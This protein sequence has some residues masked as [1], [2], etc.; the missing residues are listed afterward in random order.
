MMKRNEKKVPGFDEII[1]ENRNRE[2]GAYQLRKRYNSATSFSILVA[3]AICTAIVIGLQLT[4]K[5]GTATEGKGIIVIVQPESYNP[6]LVKPPEVKPPRDLIKPPQNVA[7]K[8][9]DSTIQTTFI[10]ITDVITA[11]TVNGDV[12]D[13]VVYIETSVD[14]VPAEPPVFI[15]VEEMPEF[16]G[17][18]SALLEFIGKNT[19]YPTEAIENN[20]EGRVILKFVVTPNGSVGKIEILKGVDPLLDKEAIRVVGTLPKFRPGKQSGVPVNVWYSVPVL[21]QIK[22]SNN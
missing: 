10:P 14:V 6:D 15:V 3:L 16:P 9:V 22:R 19:V 18:N 21:F 17:G 13:T 1:F 7:P 12:N 20:I 4:T 2:Y 8:V 11:T 5:P